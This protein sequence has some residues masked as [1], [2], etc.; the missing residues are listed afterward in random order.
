M[1]ATTVHLIAC[2]LVFS[3][4]EKL[5]PSSA[6]HKWWRR[7]LLVDVCSWLILPLAVSGGIALAVLSTDALAAAG[8]RNGW[9]DWLTQM[10]AG[11]GRVSL[12]IQIAIAF[13]AVD[14]LSYWVHRAYHRFPLLW[15]FHLMH[16]SSENLDWLSTL[17]L[18]P[19]SQ[20]INTAVIAAP[21]LLT[22]LP[23]KAVLVANALD[24]FSAELVHANVP[25][26]FG[27]LRY[28]FVS[29]V[30]HHWHHARS[31]ANSETKPASNFGAALSI[32]DRIFRT[33]LH[34]PDRPACFGVDDAPAPNFWSLIFH[35]LRPYVSNIQRVK[36]RKYPRNRSL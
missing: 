33:S 29:P 13:L 18:H 8:E 9:W 15:S 6:P 11:L 12:I 32:W 27:P 31:H 30:F 26:N 24:G 34:C 21:L 35:P 23:V 10:R 3:F 14:F 2:M 17:R 5:W 16:H 4:V 36:K 22:G 20:M 28:L 25:W 1:I 19:I 7:P